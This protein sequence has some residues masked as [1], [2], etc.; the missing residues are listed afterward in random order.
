VRVVLFQVFNIIDRKHIGSTEFHVF[1]LFHPF[2][3][4]YII[5]HCTMPG[6]L[7]SI[8]NYI[9][10]LV[11]LHAGYSANQCTLILVSFILCMSYVMWM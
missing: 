5:E 2:L 6:G 10:I 1:S 8:L 3:Q 11:L 9:G 4:T 7:L